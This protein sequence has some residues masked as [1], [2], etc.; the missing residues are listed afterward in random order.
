MALGVMA[1]AFRE[2]TSSKICTTVV[3][4]FVTRRDFSEA[5]ANPNAMKMTLLVLEII[6][7]KE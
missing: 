5:T 7:E 3:P 2:L 1:R 4:F 6:A